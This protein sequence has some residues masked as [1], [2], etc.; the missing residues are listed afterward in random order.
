M[1]QHRLRYFKNNVHSSEIASVGL[2]P[3]TSPSLPQSITRKRS[4]VDLQLLTTDD[5]D[6]E[7]S[8]QSQRE[9]GLSRN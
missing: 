2:T 6:Q 8:S 9:R 7:V 5:Q 3:N 1:L 4:T